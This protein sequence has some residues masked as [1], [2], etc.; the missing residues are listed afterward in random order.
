MNNRA[1]FL[2]GTAVYEHKQCSVCNI[3][4]ENDDVIEKNDSERT[5][6]I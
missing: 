2:N 5:E 6:I 3:K 4:F 1:W